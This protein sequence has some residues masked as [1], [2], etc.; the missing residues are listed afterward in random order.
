MPQTVRRRLSPEDRRN[1][2]LDCAQHIILSDG[3]SSL[4]ME[5][6]ANK[7]SVS[8]PLIYKYFA[9]RLQI[10]Q[11]LLIREYGAFR[12]SLAESDKSTTNYRVAV[13]RY[14]DINFRQFSSGDILGILLGQPDVRQV[15]HEKER[16]RYAPHFI[17]EMAKEFGI[18]RRLAEKVVVL[19]SG[20]SIAAAEHYGRYGGDRET[21][22]DQAVSFIFGGIESLLKTQSTD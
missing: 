12:E 18:R 17:N 21:Q 10:L 2:L 13:R 22:I 6:L 5:L 8:N 4:T 20:A 1:Q 19:A 11:E 14:V 7:A 3:L 15:I 16:P 9:T